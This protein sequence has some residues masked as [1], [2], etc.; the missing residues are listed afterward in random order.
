[1]P[2]YAAVPLLIVGYVRVDRQSCATDGKFY[3]L[4]DSCVIIIFSVDSG[5]VTC[6]SDHYLVYR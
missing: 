3:H 1:M 4:A 2:M 5:K 6:A